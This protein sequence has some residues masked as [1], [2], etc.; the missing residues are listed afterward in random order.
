MRLPGHRRRQALGDTDAGRPAVSRS[1][2]FADRR[3]IGRKSADRNSRAREGF[4]ISADA[5]RRR[6]RSFKEDGGLAR[7]ITRFPTTS[8]RST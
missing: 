1:W 5:E 3:L 6:Y 8:G 7:R 4:T 2:Q